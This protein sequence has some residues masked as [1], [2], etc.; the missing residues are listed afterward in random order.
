[1][2][3]VSIPDDN[4]SIQ[5]I[6]SFIMS[7]QPYQNAF[8]SAMV[9]RIAMTLVT[10]KMWTNPWAVF[11]MGQMEFGETIEEIFVNIAK[12]YSFDPQTAEN[13]V[14]KRHIPDVRSAFHRMNF[15][16]VYP[17]TITNDQLRQ[18]FIAWS[19][20]ADLVAKI[21]QSMYTAMNK[22]EYVVSKYMAAREMLNGGMYAIT[23]PAFDKAN[24]QDIVTKIKGTSDNLTFLSPKYNK[25][26]VENASDKNEQYLILTADQN[27][28][29]DVNVL[30]M[31]FNM[32]KAEFAGHIILV[33]QDWAEHDWARLDQ[34]F[35]GVEG[36]EHFNGTE[37]QA[38]QAVT[39]VIVDR[40]WWM[41]FDNFQEMSE[42]YNGAGLYWN[43]WLHVWKTFSVSPFANAVVFTS[44]ASAVTSVTVSPA[45]ANVSQGASLALTATVVG[46]G[47]VDKSVAW[48]ISGQSQSGTVIAGNV[49][50][51]STEEAPDTVITVTA[52]SVDGKT[53]TAQITVV[54][55]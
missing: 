43:Y 46:T 29:Y 53:G 11:K 39:G 54:A 32:D 4:R 30:A 45:T 26:Q 22:D 23:T 12:P 44:Q 14:F 50:T 40:N 13:E 36:Y 41:I 42:N 55:A 47:L 18:A 27:A 52:T 35:E 21:V 19:G 6:G 5:S 37:L 3:P 8:L 24:A 2:N 7:Y 48:S 51:V 17:D 25:A 20:I 9:N 31:S 10:S 33:D 16:K 49:L 28:I 1:M 38:L 15:Q 34:L